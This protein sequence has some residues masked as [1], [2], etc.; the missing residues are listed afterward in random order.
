MEETTPSS[1]V[2]A[3][4]KPV[5]P[6][7]IIHKSNNAPL[8]GSIIFL[9]LV[10]GAAAIFLGMQKR[11]EN[12][13]LTQPT[14]TPSQVANQTPPTQA[15]QPTVATPGWLTLTSEKM[16]NLSFSGFTMSYPA[17]WIKVVNKEE[18]TNTI[19]LTKGTYE[20]T[21]SQIPTEGTQ[22]VF[23]DPMPSKDENPF[24]T[25]YRD[26]EFVEIKLTDGTL[27]RVESTSQIKTQKTY[28]FCYLSSEP[29]AIYGAPTRYGFISYTTPATQDAATLA[30]M[31]LI[32]K[33][34]KAL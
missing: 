25:D 5:P 15:P 10:I 34:L 1:S 2:Q 6:S 3:P 31:D 18:F 28:S 29:K 9:A 7:A 27:R 22:C 17:E 19:T 8:V 33:T 20:I 32:T 24:T 16:P 14:P 4:I 26:T 12:I 30:E 21:V 13:A 11:D 23:E